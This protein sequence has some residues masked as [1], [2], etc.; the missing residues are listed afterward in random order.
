MFGKNVVIL[1]GSVVKNKGRHVKNKNL[2]FGMGIAIL[3]LSGLE[4][5]KL[6]LMKPPL[7]I[8]HQLKPSYT[9]KGI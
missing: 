3:G 1:T 8:W 9:L 2:L 4:E 7:P 6:R 5:P